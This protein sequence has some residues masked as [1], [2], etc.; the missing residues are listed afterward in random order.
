V[1]ERLLQLLR[2]PP[3]EVT[4]AGETRSFE[5]QFVPTTSY[6]EAG[7]GGRRLS[8]FTDIDLETGKI[9]VYAR[10]ATDA[11][12]EL[13]EHI[14]FPE[15][16]GELP[17]QP[18]QYHTLAALAEGLLGGATFAGTKV[19]VV[20]PTRFLEEL[21]LKTAEEL[22]AFLNAGLGNTQQ[23]QERFGTSAEG[24]YA[25]AIIAALTSYAKT[26]QY[27]KQEAA[28][29][30]RIRQGD[31][32]PSTAAL[33]RETRADLI[34]ARRF[35]GHLEQ[36]PG[37]A[38]DPAARVLAF[39]LGNRHVTDF[40]AELED[41]YTRTRNQGVP[42]AQ[43]LFENGTKLLIDW[44]PEL[45]PFLTRLLPFIG[46]TDPAAIAAAI[47]EVPLTGEHAG[48]ARQ[49]LALLFA[50][51]EKQP[52]SV[53]SHLVDRV[54]PL[55]RGSQEASLSAADAWVQDVLRELAGTQVGATGPLTLRENVDAL[56]TV[57]EQRHRTRRVSHWENAL[58]IQLFGDVRRLAEAGNGVEHL[59]KL[60][61]AIQMLGVPQPV[62][63]VLEGT[64]LPRGEGAGDFFKEIDLIISRLGI[65]DD[66]GHEAARSLL[67]RSQFGDVTELEPAQLSALLRQAGAHDDE[68]IAQLQAA[69]TARKA[70]TVRQGEGAVE[71]RP[72]LVGLPS[73]GY[74]PLPTPAGPSAVP[75][76]IP[77][78]IAQPAGSLTGL[79]FGDQLRSLRLTV[80]GQDQKDLQRAA[81]ASRYPGLM[82]GQHVSQ[83]AIEQDADVKE[84]VW[85]PISL[86]TF[87]PRGEDAAA[88]DEAQTAAY[89]Y[90]TLL[91]E[92]RGQAEKKGAFRFAL[93]ADGATD[94]DQAEQAVTAFLRAHPELELTRADFDVV[95]PDVA[96]RIPQLLELAVT[97]GRLGGALGAAAWNNGV[98]SAA[99]SLQWPRLGP[100]NDRMVRVDLEPSAGA[101]LVRSAG[102]AMIALIEG[103]VAATTVDGKLPPALADSLR[104]LKVYERAT[105]QF[106]VN[107]IATLG[108]GA[109]EYD[110]SK[111]AVTPNQ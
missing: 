46:T 55:L 38:Q 16:S 77:G 73:V 13:L 67:Q 17:L 65:T 9:T 62:K 47:R 39:T 3:A 41:R 75:V 28:L 61:A 52:S 59:V 53:N 109:D 20:V 40:F 26:A 31:K 89:I 82:T 78:P 33:L 29:E 81:L 91:T 100:A 51:P 35:L 102:A 58:Y 69:L 8:A 68:L 12:H 57:L 110:A 56:K 42:T 43:T 103:G 45:V 85:F 49:F 11:V 10:S 25:K 95:L 21:K 1:A 18:E 88:L 74:M 86:S 23:V 90:K 37:E 4:I 70:E 105:G 111:D 60:L 71:P 14:V 7:R 108:A 99:E 92:L 15:L 34:T 64:F 83:G 22:E 5:L 106:E 63:D 72:G 54:G 98:F 97:G 50:T 36:L 104:R 84:P 107:A 76:V 101:G 44:A 27:T 96:E 6:L 19:P 30:E 80:P 87:Q 94:Q 93:V 32:T 79:P 24:A 2:A 66:A 48:E